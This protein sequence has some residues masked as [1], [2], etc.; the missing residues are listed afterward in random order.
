M[1]ETTLPEQH[2][3]IRIHIAVR[4]HLPLPLPLPLT[5]L[6]HYT[7]TLHHIIHMYMLHYRALPH[8]PLHHTIQ[9]TTHLPLP[10]P[11]PTPHTYPLY[12]YGYLYPLHLYPL[13][14]YPC[15][16]SCTYSTLQLC[17]NFSLH[18][19]PIEPI[20]SGV[21]GKQDT[22]V[23]PLPLLSNGFVAL[24]LSA[25]VYR[26]LRYYTMG[27]DSR[28]SYDT[29]TFSAAVIEVVEQGHDPDSL[30]TWLTLSYG[31][32]D[33]SALQ[34]AQ[35]AYSHVHHNRNRTRTPPATIALI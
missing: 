27:S 30:E 10:L 21:R 34:C 12:M 22:L 29:D 24:P 14:L 25:Y 8:T 4:V 1:K 26:F 35:D 2:Q 19:V 31:I 33:D 17:L 18:S 9:H 15:C 20:L 3:S 28:K 23:K 16:I 5:Y 32:D 13:H 11:L 6:L 7:Y